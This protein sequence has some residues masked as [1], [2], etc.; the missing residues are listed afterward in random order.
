MTEFP[1]EL[2]IKE[3][4]S[5]SGEETLRCTGLLRAVPGKRQIYDAVWNEKPVIAKMFSHKISAR[6]HLDREVKGLTQLQKRRLNSARPLFCGRAEDG[7]WA[8]VIEKIVNSTTVLHILT[9][10]T[11]KNKILDLLMQVCR[12]LA[13]QHSQGVVQKDLH[14]GNFLQ[15][16]DQIY[17]LDPGQMQ[18]FPHPVPRKKSISQ[19]AL[20]VCCLPAGDT[21]SIE[22]LC[23]EY[24]K[25]RG[26]DFGSSDKNRLEQQ[27]ALHRKRG[28]RHGLK[29]CLRTSKRNRRMKTG[30]FVAV[31]DR[32]FCHGT[33]P[34]DLIKHI[35]TL[36]DAGHILKNG[37]TCYVSHFTYDGLNI[38]VKRYNHQG[39]IHSLRHTLKRSRA[40]RGWLHAHHFGMREIPTPKPLAYIERRKGW[41]IWNSYLV[42]QYAEGPSLYHFLRDE[43]V[44]PEQRVSTTQ[45]VKNLL[46]Q[47]ATYR[48][49]HGD[50]KHTNILI[51]QNGPTLTDLDSVQF[52]KCNWLYRIRSAKDREHFE[53]E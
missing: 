3:T 20:L 40:R 16:E 7:R 43:N 30:G 8:V 15:A 19:L 51:T 25:T 32:S 39:L 47:L 36:M 9:E 52:H 6:R 2:R 18:F 45:Q 35:D 10:T 27:M 37:N 21:T 29:K 23:K 44:T 38:V 33:E 24:F 11:G 22:A 1:F 17:T 42:T 5:E 26:W 4:S 34:M 31:F 50:L 14:L 48:I 12:E 41:L 49:T 53:W 28:I 46:D 13:K